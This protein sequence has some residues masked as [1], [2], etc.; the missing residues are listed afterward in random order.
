IIICI[1]KFLSYFSLAFFS[2]SPHLTTTI[3][4]FF[5]AMKEGMLNL[6]LHCKRR[7]GH[8]QAS[9]K[10]KRK[11]KMIFFDDSRRFIRRR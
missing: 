7:Y 3:T 1:N 11:R 4:I 10:K 8:A 9:K 5:S 6:K 2:S